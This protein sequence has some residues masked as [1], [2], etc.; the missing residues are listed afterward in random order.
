MNQSVHFLTNSI[1]GSSL[2]ITQL[3]AKFEVAY[4][5]D[6]FHTGIVYMII[7][8]KVMHLRK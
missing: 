5:L 1:I 2:Y 3:L 8:Y 4:Y 7:F 6:T